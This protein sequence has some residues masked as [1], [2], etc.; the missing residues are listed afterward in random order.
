MHPPA[1]GGEG[2]GAVCRVLKERVPEPLLRDLFPS[3]LCKMELGRS[4]A[5]RLL[6]GHELLSHEGTRQTEP[7][8]E[9]SDLAPVENVIQIIGNVN[10]LYFAKYL[11][12]VC[13]I[14]AGSKSGL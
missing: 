5:S 2:R 1:H 4:S 10:L 6:T 3:G 9:P 14:N 7:R 11:E 12:Y 8:S 13:F